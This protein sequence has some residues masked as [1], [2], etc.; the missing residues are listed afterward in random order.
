MERVKYGVS[1]QGFALHFRL[2]DEKVK[3][4]DIYDEDK[5]SWSSILNHSIANVSHHLYI[6]VLILPP[7]LVID[8]FWGCKPFLIDF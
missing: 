1:N 4:L 6:L 3:I 8:L 5:F 2:V 7:Q